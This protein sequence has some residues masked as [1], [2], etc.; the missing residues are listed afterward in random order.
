M[1]RVAV[2]A[3][4]RTRAG[5]HGV[6]RHGGANRRAAAARRSRQHGGP[7]VDGDGRG[8]RRQ[9]RVSGRVIFSIGGGPAPRRSRSAH[10]APER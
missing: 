8:A 5:L 6:S 7:V 3:L 4:A 9:A 10:P 2:A 1:L